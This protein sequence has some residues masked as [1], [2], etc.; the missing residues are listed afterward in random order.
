MTCGFT[1]TAPDLASWHG[2]STRG[3]L[4]LVSPRQAGAV[5]TEAGGFMR[6]TAASDI[7]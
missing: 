3:A 5:V 1:A 7:Q 6:L 4:V 2:P